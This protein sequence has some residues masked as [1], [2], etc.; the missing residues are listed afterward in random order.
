MLLNASGSWGMALLLILA[1]GLPLQVAVGGLVALGRTIPAAAALLVPLLLVLLG[2]VG[3]I[4]GLDTAVAS[5]TQAADPAWV[6]WFALDDRARAMI[7]AAL[8]GGGAALLALPPAL[9]AAWVN[10]RAGALPT[11]AGMTLQAA[12][13]RRWALPGL[14]LAVAAVIAMGEAVAGAVGSGAWTLWVPALGMV[15]FAVAGALAMLPSKRKGLEGVVIGYGAL[16]IASVGLGTAAS[17]LAA[18][19]AAVALGDFSAPFAAVGEVA[20]RTREVWFVTRIAT[21]GAAGFVASLLP[22]LLVRDWRRVDARIGTDAL[23][24]GAL[25][26]L[27]LMAGVWAGARERVLSHYAGGYGAAVLDNAAGYDVPARV[28]IPS[29][30]LIGPVISPRWLMQ[31]DRGGVEIL[32][33]SGGLDIIGPALL[34]NDGLLL[35]PTVS[36]E[37][38]YLALFQSDAGRI[39]IVGCPTAAPA[40]LQD[41]RRDPLLATGRCAA[42]P[43]ELRVTTALDAPR[44]LIA[45]ADRF[46]DDGG[47]VLPVSE[48]TDIAGRDVVLRGQIDATVG[49]LVAVLHALAPAARVYLGWGVTLEGGNLPIGVDPGLRIQKTA[50]EALRGQEMD[51]AQPL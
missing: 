39:A 23:V 20:A 37:D 1:L 22:A 3:T 5:L 26:L 49:D 11:P 35:P 43:L 45:L 9:G 4:A 27:G 6:P 38:L 8:G 50:F 36:L 19:S 21:F 47:D 31:R 41:I 14:G 44:V 24:C 16:G 32:P 12:Q 7:P 28:P 34:R 15:P 29:R 17:A 40:L 51:A 13:A 42:F 46:V 10:L 30:V 33:F 48:L 25:A 18:S 2:F